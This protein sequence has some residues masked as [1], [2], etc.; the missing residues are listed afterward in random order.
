MI[1]RL[2]FFFETKNGHF[3]HVLP[4]SSAYWDL[5]SNTAS[6][7]ATA[8]AQPR[9]YYTTVYASLKQTLLQ[10]TVCEA[11]RHPSR[12]VGTWRYRRVVASNS[13]MSQRSMAWPLQ[14]RVVPIVASEYNLVASHDQDRSRMMTLAGSLGGCCSPTVSLCYLFAFPSCFSPLVQTHCAYY[15]CCGLAGNMLF[16]AET[17]GQQILAGVTAANQWDLTN[18]CSQATGSCYDLLQVNPVVF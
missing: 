14:G 7:W 11:S 15:M 8:L 3:N 6:G 4:V 16:V 13:A 12:V 17:I 2:F 9:Q 5:P 1:T 10:N 18:G